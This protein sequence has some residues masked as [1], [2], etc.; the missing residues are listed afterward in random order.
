MCGLLRVENT[1]GALLAMLSM[2]FDPGFSQH[3]SSEPAIWTV[4]AISCVRRTSLELE[5]MGG[6]A[7]TYNRFAGVNVIDN[8]LHLVVG[9]IAKTSQDHQQIG[10]VERFQAGNIVQLIGIDRAVF[11]IDG[12]QNG[13]L[14][15]MVSG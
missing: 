3:H 8:V 15:A 7:Q 9:Q 10:R 14:E 12:K 11:R 6:G 13:A 1:P 2:M 4:P 5:S